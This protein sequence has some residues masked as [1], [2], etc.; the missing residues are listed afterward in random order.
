MIGV[1]FVASLPDYES[2]LKILQLK[3]KTHRLSPE[4]DL[5]YIAKINVVHNG[6]DKIRV[7]WIKQRKFKID[8]N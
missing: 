4:V 2:R 8:R 6:A 7:L 3:A 1:S 5:D